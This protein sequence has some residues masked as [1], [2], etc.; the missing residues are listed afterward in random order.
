MNR[1]PRNVV[2]TGAGGFVGRR[3]VAHL[4]A[5][6]LAD[7][8]LADMRLSVNDMAL[9]DL[10][11]DPR[12]RAVPGDFGDPAVRHALLEGG[13]DVL[14]HLGGVLGGAAERA[15]AL[16]R[17]VNLDATVSLLEAL[18]PS[19]TEPS[20]ATQSPTRVVFASSI[21]VFGA[22][23]PASIDD[24]TR[25]N[26]SMVYGAQKAMVETLIEQMS[27]RGWIDGLALR[28]PGIVARPGADAR[29]KT[30]FLNRLFEVFAEGV[31][32]TLPVS[33][34]GST[35]LL[36]TRACVDAL[37]HAGD[38]AAERLGP[39]RAFTLPAQNVRFGELV[40]ALHA[41]F[42]A[43]PT[44]IRYAPD[45]A[46]EAQFGRQPPLRTPL[47]DALGFRHDGDIATLVARAL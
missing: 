9:P 27:A 36:S 43:S 38:L 17:R 31:D 28:L 37:V 8:A 4:V 19:P 25:I 34:E 20:G 10:P 21:A 35:W 15:P 14:Y 18:A 46:I 39:R 5:Q 7:P 3:L 40:A 6:W 45:E 24:D 30:A 13:V 12:L 29:L 26:P 16:A 22:P 32:L 33:P 42:P 44:V 2:V 47:A 11:A 23:M 1:R 41:R